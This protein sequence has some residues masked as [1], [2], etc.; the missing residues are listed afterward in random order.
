M[1]I[2]KRKILLENSVDRGYESQTYGQLTATSFYVNIILTQN[3]DDM[4]MFTDIIY[5]PNFDN[6]TPV[7]YTILKNKLISS[8]ITFPF[9]NGVIP[10]DND[11]LEIEYQ[12]R[13]ISKKQSDYYDFNNKTISGR[14]ESRVDDVKSY[15]DLNP[16]ILNFDITSETYIN[17][18]GKTVNGVDRVTSLNPTAFT[19]VFG[20][21]SNDPNIGTDKQNDGF[22]FIETEGS[23]TS[24]FSYISQGWNQTNTSLSGI[25]KEEYLFGIISKPEIKSD[26][27]IDRGITTVFDRH[28]PMS[29]ITNSV[30][31]F[32]YKNGFYKPIR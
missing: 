10:D 6:K 22:L 1:E 13:S 5:L 20:V 27:F 3:I 14:T 21:D 29:E 8:G 7:D 9:M 4:G 24:K 15:N 28:L 19:Y 18:T 17:F 2:I 16:Y 26:V 23:D 31:L 25:T 11:N 30:Q 32:R 12:T